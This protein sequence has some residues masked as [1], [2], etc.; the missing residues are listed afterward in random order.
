MT[1]CVYYKSLNVIYSLST[2]TWICIHR[3][4]VNKHI[5]F[6]LAALTNKINTF[7]LHYCIQYA[8]LI[9]FSFFLIWQHTDM[10]KPMSERT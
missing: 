10:H 9:V 5:S 7:Y 1:Q 2:D 4:V 8:I 3:I 6:Y